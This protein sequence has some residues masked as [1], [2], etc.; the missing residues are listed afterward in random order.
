MH[1]QTRQELYSVLKILCRRNENY[2][3]MV[4]SL[5]DSIPRGLDPVFVVRA[6]SLL[7]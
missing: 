3:K 1:G 4:E 7:T 2:L 5:E 6:A